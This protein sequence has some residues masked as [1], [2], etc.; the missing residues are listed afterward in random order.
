MFKLIHGETLSDVNSNTLGIFKDIQ[1]LEGNLVI[2]E[3]TSSY[4]QIKLRDGAFIEKIEERIISD[5]NEIYSICI[6]NQN[7]EII[8]ISEIGSIELLAKST[9]NKKNAFLT[10]KVRNR[11]SYQGVEKIWKLK[12]S[13][14]LNKK[15]LWKS[16]TEQEKWGWL[17]VALKSH[18]KD[19]K[20]ITKTIIIEGKDITDYPSF[21]CA[22]GE[23]ANGPGGYFGW[24]LDALYDCLIG[25]WGIIFPAKVLWINHLYSKKNLK[26]K[27][28]QIISVF[29]DSKTKLELK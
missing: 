5:L 10:L 14:N 4:Y 27:Y 15:G 7:Q 24:N 6:L 18:L 8:G 25:G 29:E 16:L 19:K 22:L 20:D 26:E 28:N 17:E 9:Q 12:V 13:N 11:P 2:K 3:K 21:Y 23:S 1:G